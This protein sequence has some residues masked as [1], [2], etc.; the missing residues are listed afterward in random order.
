MSAAANAPHNI[1]RKNSAGRE[2]AAISDLHAPGCGHE[3]MTANKSE[4][5]GRIKKASGGPQ[6]ECRRR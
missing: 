5:G 6:W 1:G 2:F 3:N 4:R